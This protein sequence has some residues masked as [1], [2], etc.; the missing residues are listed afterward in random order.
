MQETLEKVEKQAF[1]QIVAIVFQWMSDKKIPNVESE[2][3]TAKLKEFISSN[4]EI[5]R[6]ANGGQ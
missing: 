1:G 2:E 3:T 4:A 6:L 5:R